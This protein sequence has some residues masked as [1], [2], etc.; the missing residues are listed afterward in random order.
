MATQ[1]EGRPLSFGLN[2]SEKG[3]ATY[4]RSG[5]T[6]LGIVPVYLRALDM[7]AAA[8]GGASPACAGRRRRSPD[9]CCGRPTRR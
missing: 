4:E 2:L 8:L 9:P 3:Y 1:L 6:D 5:W 7:A